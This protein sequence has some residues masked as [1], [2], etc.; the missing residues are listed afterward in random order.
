MVGC[1]T[2]KPI[3]PNRIGHGRVIRGAWIADMRLGKIGSVH[4]LL[5]L[6]LFMLL[7]FPFFPVVHPV[8]ADTLSSVYVNPVQSCCV[9][10]TDSTPEFTVNVM[11]NLTS[12]ESI[13]GF[14]VRLNYTN[15]YSPSPPVKGV[16]QAKSLDFSNN[17]FASSFGASQVT[18]LASCIDDVT[19]A[20]STFGGFCATDDSTGGQV[21]VAQ[22]ILNGNLTGPVNNALLFSVTFG[23]YQTGTS[24]FTIERAHLSNTGGLPPNPHF[25]PVTTAAGVF[26]DTQLVAFFDYQS[27]FSPSVLAGVS[28]R[29]DA[30]GSFRSS[31]SAKSGLSSP[32]FKW[33]FGDG[34][35][36]TSSAPI[37]FHTF[38]RE[39][40]YTVALNVTD[41][42][43]GIGSFQRNVQVLP[44]LGTLHVQIKN[45][46][47][48]SLQSI[49]TVKLHNLTSPVP[50]LCSSCSKVMTAGGF[51]D[52]R[53]LV[54]GSYSMNFTGAGVASSGKVTQVQVGWPTMETVYLTEIMLPA[55][56]TTPLIIFG[57]VIGVGLSLAG[58]GL[59]LRWRRTKRLLK[60]DEL[61][62]N[63][64]KSG[65]T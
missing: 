50:P 20:T 49:I 55:P 56:N 61:S 22:I 5:F 36:T 32:T 60:A 37:A 39:G 51:V 1:P 59:A 44:D 33:N 41:V 42:L 19:F 65:R 16:L 43:P 2:D 15:F 25:I 3:L 63:T 34:N 27:T 53:G 4:L 11:M 26:G 45:Q 12:S 62:R 48:G 8:V 38:R 54:P 29:L 58:L 10:P 57:I 31:G 21:H 17:V 13:A 14:D 9:L 30:S 24:L 64:R 28:A 35:Q 23:V 52:F 46:N 7:R 47:G 6:G 40:N 18:T